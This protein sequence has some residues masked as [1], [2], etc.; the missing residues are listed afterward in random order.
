MKLIE[1]FICFNFVILIVNGHRKFKFN[2]GDWDRHK[3]IHNLSYHEP[4][5][6]NYH[7]ISFFSNL[8]R[9]YHHNIRAD[10]GYETYRLGTNR[11]SDM[12]FSDFARRMLNYKPTTGNV[13][14]LYHYNNN[15]R[16]SS[17]NGAINR[18]QSNESLQSLDW[19][20]SGFVARVKNQGLC[21]SCWAFSVIAAIESSTAIARNRSVEELSEQ[22][23]IDCS[24][25]NYGCKGGRLDL[26]FQFVLDNG[27]VDTESSYPY[28]GDT[29]GECRFNSS[30]VG[31]AIQSYRSILPKAED[32]LLDA[33]T[34]HVVSAAIQVT[35]GFQLYS[36]GIFDDP[37]CSNNE[38]DLNHAIA[39]IGFGSSGG[40]DWWLI[41]NSW[42]PTWG[43]NGYGRIARGKNTC[44]IAFNAIYPVV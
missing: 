39:I 44:G 19:R 21:G 23:L 11:Y 35:Q 18:P 1:L 41:K 29:I 7:R 12:E 36:G 28:E 6:E 2:P 26:A 27:G 14:Q 16:K 22:N 42:G 5:K 40:Q 38:E 9:I 34:N 32:D 37:T 33:A 25:K 4:R 3:M 20:D 15:K 24:K 30:T 31:A 8:G 17:I 13:R 43:E 10:K